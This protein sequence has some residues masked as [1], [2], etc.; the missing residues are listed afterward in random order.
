MTDDDN[1]YQGVSTT[2]S[3]SLHEFG[4]RADCD[5]TTVSRLLSGD[6]APSTRL[7]ARICK[8]FNLDEGEALRVLAEDQDTGGG[9]TPKFAEYLRVKVIDAPSEAGNVPGAPEDL[10]REQGCG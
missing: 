9:R 8:A 3:L 6:R 4:Q 7:L 2:M 10:T 5:Y 1:R